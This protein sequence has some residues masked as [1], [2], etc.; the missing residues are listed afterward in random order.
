MRTFGTFL[1]VTSL[2]ISAWAEELG[3][4]AAEIDEAELLAEASDYKVR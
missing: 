4:P 2:T 3:L 1:F